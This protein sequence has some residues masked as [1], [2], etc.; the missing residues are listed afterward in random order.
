MSVNEKINCAME[1][2][3]KLKEFTADYASATSLLCD[4]DKRICPF[5]LKD[6]DYKTMSPE[7]KECLLKIYDDFCLT[8]QMDN[9]KDIDEVTKVDLIKEFLDE[10][11]SFFHREE[12]RIMYTEAFRRLQYKTQVMI[13]SASDDQRTRL[14]HSLE[15]QKIS[16]KIS[17]GL[18]ANYELAETIAL[19]HDIGH[20]PFGHAG[21][22]A[23]NDYLEDH[24]AGA[25]SHALQS[26]KVI[27]FLCSHRKLKEYR[28]RGL[29]VSD[30]V[31]EGVLKHD[32]DAFSENIAKPKYRLQY[33]CESLY[34]PVG[35]SEEDVL[36]QFKENEVYIGGIESQIVH[37][38]DKIA[39]M[40][41]DWEEFVSVDLLEVMLSRINKMVI[42]L[43]HYLNNWDAPQYEFVTPTEETALKEFNCSYLDFRNYYYSENYKE[44][45]A[46]DDKFKNH[47][48]TV[49]EQLEKIISLCDDTPSLML[50]FSKEQY[51]ILHSFFKIAWAWIVLTK[52][53]PRKVSGKLDLI[54]VIY[55]YLCE[56]TAH[57]TVPAL[58]NSLIETSNEEIKKA[59]NGNK[60]FS[61]KDLI[62]Y[63]NDR[64]EK[65]KNSFDE[66]TKSFVKKMAYKDSLL[67]KYN[68]DYAVAAKYVNDFIYSQYID[69]T[70]IKFMTQK[71]KQIVKHLMDF[72]HEHPEMLPIK[73]RKRIEFE[74]NFTQ[75]RNSIRD[76][77]VEYYIDFLQ[78][79]H[80][81]KGK[82]T[83]FSIFE[84]HAPNC[85]KEKYNP[86][87]DLKKEGQQKLLKNVFQ[88]Y[89]EIINDVIRLRVIADYISGM[90]DRLAEK[91]YN[92]IFSSTTSW[93]KEFSEK[94]TFNV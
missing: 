77:L 10:N 65:N 87:F 78:N 61:R 59:S 24:M 66:T 28:I 15:V 62:I 8:L 60:N 25:F 3:M 37:W 85:E 40:S 39:Y 23:I 4:N 89:R 81:V 2:S 46:N 72:F 56:T 33:N 43:D 73:Q 48:K 29:G 30:Y 14:L 55:K 52:R 6:K 93:T 31:L 34:K 21:E 84:K 83:V 5:D 1:I 7:E 22:H 71:A 63:C 32:A 11:R 42:E 16:R 26:V 18:R 67:V 44:D 69:S 49:W 68:G 51:E 80:S 36:A 54:F 57:R 27:D 13:N 88:D 50:L 92:E 41:H 76:L 35:I 64:W 70:R 17:I 12:E 74:I 79:N 86:L 58:V 90:T 9:Y 20:A 47:L 94:G 75:K 45:D 82:E 38:A 53:T 91:K 19:A